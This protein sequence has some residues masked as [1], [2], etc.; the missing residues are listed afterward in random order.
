MNVT[1]D[2]KDMGTQMKKTIVKPE[3]SKLRRLKTVP[4]C[5]SLVR[6]LSSPNLIFAFDHVWSL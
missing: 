6:C 2:P 1:D 3:K 4:S 5:L